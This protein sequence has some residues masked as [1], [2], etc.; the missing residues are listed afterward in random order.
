MRPEAA[1]SASAQNT[2]TFADTTSSRLQITG[3]S[4]RRVAAY[5]S[6]CRRVRRAMK[7][8]IVQPERPNNRSSLLA[9]GSTARRY[10]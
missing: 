6:S 8:S 1:A 10:A 3:R 2:K 5:C 4:R 7:R 9:G